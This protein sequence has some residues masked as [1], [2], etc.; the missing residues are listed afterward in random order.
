MGWSFLF[1]LR[2]KEGM[3]RD[4][5][6]YGAPRGSGNQGNAHSCS[7]TPHSGSS[8]PSYM[9]PITLHYKEPVMVL[10]LQLLCQPLPVLQPELNPVKCGPYED[11]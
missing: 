11:P 2:S 7:A 5:W 3:G 9:P 1:D 4:P 6:A 10:Q 8:S